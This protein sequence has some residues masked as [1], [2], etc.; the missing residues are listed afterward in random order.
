[1]III[2]SSQAI[3]TDT[4]IS[5]SANVESV[6]MMFLSAAPILRRHKDMIRFIGILGCPNLQVRILHFCLLFFFS[7]V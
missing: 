6:I 5:P 4:V 3:L 2:C 7:L 1:M